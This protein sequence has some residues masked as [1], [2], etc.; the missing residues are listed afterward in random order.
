MAGKRDKY[1]PPDR[2]EMAKLQRMIDVAVKLRKARRDRHGI[3]LTPTEVQTLCGMLATLNEAI[4]EAR[5]DPV[6]TE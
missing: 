2:A 6:I 1:A 3:S 4:K 5:A